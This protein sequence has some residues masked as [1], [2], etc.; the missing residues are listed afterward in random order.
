[1]MIKLRFAFEVEFGNTQAALAYGVALGSMLANVDQNAKA[2]CETPNAVIRRGPI[3]C[4]DAVPAE[5]RA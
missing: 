5:N 3:E 1:M 4:T 2:I